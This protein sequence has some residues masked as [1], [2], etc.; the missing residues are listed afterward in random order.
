MP[1]QLPLSDTQKMLVTFRVEPGCL[2]PQGGQHA[3]EFCAF[4]QREF[5]LNENTYV[6]W[7]IVPRNDKSAPE[8]E[9]SWHGKKITNEQSAR[10]LRTFEHDLAEFEDA[11]PTKFV[12]LIERYFERH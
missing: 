3:E 9:Y 6:D 5:E 10:Y 8:M 11:V 2:G 7:H 1:A 12:H 4:A